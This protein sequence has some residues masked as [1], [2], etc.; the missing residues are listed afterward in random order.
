[1]WGG[2]SVPAMAA[3]FAF[4]HMVSYVVVFFIFFPASL[5]L[6]DVDLL[7]FPHVPIRDIA[8]GW[9]SNAIPRTGC[10]GWAHLPPWWASV[11]VPLVLHWPTTGLS[12]C[13]LLLWVSFHCPPAVFLVNG[14][15]C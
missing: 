1:M 6:A 15:P 9:G 13:V 2:F 7:H 5:Q 11:V 4:I 10:M 12:R 14:L 3:P 8:L